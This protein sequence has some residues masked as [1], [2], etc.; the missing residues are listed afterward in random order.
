MPWK[1]VKAAYEVTDPTTLHDDELIAME[2]ALRQAIGEPQNEFNPAWRAW[3]K[4]RP[5]A[6]QCTGDG[7]P[8]DSLPDGAAADSRLCDGE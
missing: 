8:V 1:I 5:L 2:R 3:S 4:V 6:A 7:D